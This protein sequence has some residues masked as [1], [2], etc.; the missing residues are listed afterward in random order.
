MMSTLPV[1]DPRKDW[2]RLVELRGRLGSSGRRISKT[3]GP[4][5]R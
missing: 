1:R 5:C 4:I 2:V 3:G